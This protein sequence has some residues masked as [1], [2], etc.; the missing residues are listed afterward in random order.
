VLRKALTQLG[1]FRRRGDGE[2]ARSI[3]VV[4]IGIVVVLAIVC[5]IAAVL[6]AAGRADDVELQQERLLLTNA[7]ADRGHRVLRELENIAAAHDVV[8]QL[9]YN[10]DRD[11]VHHL[12][13]LRLNTFFDHDHVF[14]TNGADRLTY[15]LEGDASVDP[16]LFAPVRAEL[17]RV[18]ALLRG[19]ATPGRDEYFQEAAIDPKTKLGH[20]RGV[21]RLQRF[22]NRPAIVAGVVAEL[23]ALAGPISGGN[24]PLLITVKFLDGQLL[25]DIGARFDLPRLRAVGADPAMA[26]ENLYVV[27]D[28]AGAAIARFAWMPNRPGA[29]IVSTVLPFMT[30]AFGGFAILTALA[31]RYIRRSAVKIAEG[32]NRLRHLALHDPLSG[33]PNRTYFGERLA[34]VISDTRNDGSVAAVLAID[35]DHF[36]DINDTLGH[37]IGD[38]LIGVVAQRLVHAVRREDLVARLGGDEFAVISTEA[39]D[40]ETMERFAERIIAVLRAPYSVSGH[41]LLIGA[42]VGIAVIDRGSGDAADIMRRADVA[43]YRAK[44][45]GRSR[46]CTYDADMDADLR[47]R[48]QLENDLRTAIAEDG[49]SVAYQPIMNASGEKM[50]GVEALCRWMHPTRGNVPPVDFIPIAERSELIIPLGEWVLRKACIEARDWD[51]LTVAVNVSPLQFRRQDFVEVVERILVETG[52]DPAR[53]ELELTESTLLGNVDD[54]EKAMQ[55][56]KA[57]G[58]RFALDDFGTGYSSLLYLRRFPFDRIKIDRSFVRSIETAADAASIVHAIVSLGRGLGMKVTAE[59]VETAEQQLFLRA[60][61][62]HSMQGFRFGK[63][64]SAAAIFERLHPASAMPLQANAS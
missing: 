46:A 53:L 13:G 27:T 35:L 38:A 57:H 32:E 47:E 52:L 16:N 24:P 17:D 60:A 58:V 51:G 56:L 63:P 39:T 29:S 20:P 37:H 49:L 33:L 4:P 21:Q 26:D 11:W 28:S 54:A 15:A 30:I 10:F 12:V 55:R 48:K 18:V 1:K 40:L 22:M 62:V 19:D 43:L 14:V 2:R 6:T 8:Y 3:G 36:K 50:A 5:V 59:G 9:H 42:S 64:S 31:L 34:E 44:N 23:P 61:G 41:T 45:E 25:S 7:I